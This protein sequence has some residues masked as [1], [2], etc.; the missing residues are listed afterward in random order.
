MALEIKTCNFFFQCLAIIR[1][2]SFMIFG[3]SE[4]EP[5]SCILNDLL[6]QVIVR[7]ENMAHYKRQPFNGDLMSPETI[8]RAK[9]FM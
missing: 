7:D 5:T 9:V 2:F 3:I 4:Q 6:G 8:K 1:R